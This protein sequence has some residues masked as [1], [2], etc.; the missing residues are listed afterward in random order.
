MNTPEQQ[1]KL[2]EEEERAKR[3][4]KILK[5]QSDLDVLRPVS[6]RKY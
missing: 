6:S 3:L 5:R 2:K 4:D 1:K